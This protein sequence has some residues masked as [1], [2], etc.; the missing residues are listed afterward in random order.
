MANS[1]HNF[2]VLVIGGGISGLGV[3]LE[4]SRLGYSTA[5]VEKGV[6]CNATSANSL[7]IIHGGFRYLQKLDFPRIF[8]SIV[9]Q[10]YWLNTAPQYV[11]PLPCFLP[12][13]KFGLKSR[14]PLQ[15]ASVMY[16]A[17]CHHFCGRPNGSRYV[18]QN[19]VEERV[20][21]LKDRVP[22]GALLWHDALLDDV[23]GFAGYVKEVISKAGTAILE[24]TRVI[25]V[26]RV[27]GGF[28]VESLSGGEQTKYHAK[29]VVNT[30]G[31]WFGSVGKQDKEGRWQP[32]GWCKA[33]NL[34]LK[35][36]LEQTFAFGLLA[37]L[38][39]VFFFVPR[40]G[41]R[42]A[43]GTW[44]TPFYGDPDSLKPDELEMRDF[45]AA[46]NNSMPGAGLSLDDVE[47]VDLGVLPMRSVNKQG[48]VLYGMHKIFNHDGFIDV[49]STKF[50][51]F[52]SQGRQVV[53]SIK[54]YLLR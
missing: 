14:Y 48:P 35:K 13:N 27:E 31:P 45:L 18:E 39:R 12:L 20:P 7:R 9:E 38:G 24:N 42:T 49:M 36:Q 41:N 2:D 6:C 26:S 33:Y 44:Y 34:I 51:T 16:E 54:P 21:V 52:R 30:S 50:T 19:Y 10:N 5:L 8:E 17:I 37:D 47:S 3:S 22:H 4:A 32:S 23:Q 15:V 11:K 40:S 28:E 1:I 25:S 43:A 46:I 53:E 29:V